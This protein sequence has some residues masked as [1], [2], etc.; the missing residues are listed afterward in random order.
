MNLPTNNPPKYAHRFFQW[1]CRPGLRDSIEGDLMELYNERKKERGK[2]NADQKFILDVLL[3]FRPG[4]VRPLAGIVNLNTNGMYKSY[5]KIGW[6][7]LLR[8]KGYSL[9]NIGGLAMGM[10]VAILI[11]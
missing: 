6:R 4:I 10:A 3:L 1:F 11:G 8:N 7:N 9:I 2:R 5:L